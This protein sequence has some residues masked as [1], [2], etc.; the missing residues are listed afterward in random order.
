MAAEIIKL[1]GKSIKT[2]W[3]PTVLRGWNGLAI[4]IV[5][6]ILIVGLVIL[7]VEAHR[8]ALHQ[9]VF[10]YEFKFSLENKA[11][12]ALAPYSIIPTLIAVLIKLWWSALEDTFK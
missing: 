9:T 2:D 3:R 10:V 12:T 8:S 1:R 11:L 4:L 7:Y 5:F 6:T